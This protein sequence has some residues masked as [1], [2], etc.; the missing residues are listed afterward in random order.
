[1]VETEQILVVPTAEF[2]RLGHFQ[3]FSHDVRR[4]LPELL[5]C[6]RLGYRP[7]GEME[8]D[9]G[10]KQL[11]P[12]VVFQYRS[13]DGVQLFQY[14][15]GHGQGEARL[16]A[17]RSVGIGGHISTLDADAIGRHFG[18][19]VYDEGM[20]RELAEEVDIQTPYSSECVGLINDDDTPVGKVHLGVVHLFDVE[21]PTIHPRE[22]DILDARFV[23]V[24]RILDE[25]DQFES[26]S[27]IVVRALFAAF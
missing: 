5:E 12:Y 22:E 9:P 20:R 19:Q 2:R 7:R 11:I 13:G 3:G 24:G 26:W 1:M 8:E 15:R 14:C 4:Y 17:K 6:D 23:S 18:R 27:Q 21:R 25:I 10:F 16:R